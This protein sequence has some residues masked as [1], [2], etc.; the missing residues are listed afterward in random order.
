VTASTVAALLTILGY[1]LYDTIIVFDRI[2]ENA[3]R[4]PNATFSQI[5][6]RSGSEVVVRSLA[7]SFSTLLPVLALLLFGGETLGDFAFALLVGI[8]SGAYSSLFIAGPLLVHWKEREP[9]YR[10]R[11]QRIVDELGY[12]PAYAATAQG[13]ADVEPPKKRRIRRSGNPEEGVSDNEFD[14]MVAN[15]GLED[16]RAA[17]GAAPRQGRRARAAAG[18]DVTPRSRAAEQPPATDESPAERDAGDDP[19]AS[20]GDG[21]SAGPNRPKGGRRKPRNSR[22]GRPR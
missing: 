17:T 1:S 6:N 10:R 13:A 9:I 20:Q 7:T 18:E 5:V 22:H 16:D 21:G 11:R 15:L 8:A 19:P 12:V 14:E 4:M 3:P 2:R